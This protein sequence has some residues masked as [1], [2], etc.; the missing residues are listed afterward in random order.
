MQGG[1]RALRLRPNWGEAWADLGWARF[2]RGDV[3]GA[4]GALDRAAALDPTHLGLRRS[5]ADFL[6]RTRKG[7]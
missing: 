4:R 6:A 5:R 1:D 3:E 7:L 2:A